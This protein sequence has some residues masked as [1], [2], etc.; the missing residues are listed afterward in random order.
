MD[1]Y[2]HFFDLYKPNTKPDEYIPYF[3]RIP[4]SCQPIDDILMKC[5]GATEIKRIHNPNQISIQ[6]RFG[7]EPSKVLMSLAA[8]KSNQIFATQH[9]KGVVFAMMKNPVVHLTIDAYRDFIASSSSN[10]Q[11]PIE[12]Y[13]GK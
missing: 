5:F 1:H 9:V 12:E 8:Y 10:S 6:S 4:Y 13:I 2:K 11:M 7:G 3:W